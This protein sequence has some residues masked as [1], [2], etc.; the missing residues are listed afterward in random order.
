MGPAHFFEVSGVYL[1]TKCHI[2]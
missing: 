1:C 2:R